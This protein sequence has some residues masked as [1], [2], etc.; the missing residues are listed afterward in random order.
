MA[1]HPSSRILLSPRYK[2][3]KTLFFRIAVAISMAPLSAMLLFSNLSTLMV[4]LSLKACARSLA[5]A[6]KNELFEQSRWTTDLFFSTPIASAFAPAPLILLS[7]T[8]TWAM[9]WFSAR[10]SPMTAAPSLVIPF[11]LR[12]KKTRTRFVLIARAMASHPLS[13]MALPASTSFMRREFV[14]SPCPIALATSGPTLSPVKSS[15]SVWASSTGSRKTFASTK[16][17]SWSSSSRA[18]A[19]LSGLPVFSPVRYGW[20]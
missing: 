14:M 9:T 8:F 20:K 12:S 11:E 1:R 5:P 18:L 10:A 4:L 19:I 13:E 7:D 16:R 6:G 15:S 3:D 2:C 17:S